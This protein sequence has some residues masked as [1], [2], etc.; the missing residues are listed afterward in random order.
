MDII[1]D[2]ANAIKII[3]IRNLYQT[4]TPNQPTLLDRLI[5]LLVICRRDVPKTHLILEIDPNADLINT[6]NSDGM[7]CFTPPIQYSLM[8]LFTQLFKN[9]IRSKAGFIGT[10][11]NPPQSYTIYYS[12]SNTALICKNII[13][14]LQNQKLPNSPWR[15]TESKSDWIMTKISRHELFLCAMGMFTPY[16]AQLALVKSGSLV[17]MLKYSRNPKNM[18]K[19]L[20]PWISKP[21]IVSI[22]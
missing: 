13:D 19:L 16:T 14:G 22:R 21:I 12:F 10:Y 7:C 5:E 3:P 20:S 6:F 2:D 11:H 18:I 17:N 8:R 1:I 9:T 4:S 15:D